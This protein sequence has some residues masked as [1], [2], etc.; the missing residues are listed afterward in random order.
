LD[1]AEE[2]LKEYRNK[3]ESVIEPS[4]SPRPLA[5]PPPLLKGG[6]RGDPDVEGLKNGRDD[7]APTLPYRTMNINDDD[8]LQD[9]AYAAAV[10]ALIKKYGFRIYGIQTAPAALIQSNDQVRDAVLDLAADPEL[11]VDNR[12]LLWMGSDVFLP[13]RAR[14]L[15]KL[16]PSPEGFIKLLGELE[17]RRIRH[18]HYWISSDGDSSWQELVEELALIIN[19]YRDFPNFGLLAHAPFIVPYPASRLFKRL[20]AETLNLKIKETLDAPDPAF[21]YVIADRLETNFPNLN[22]LLNNEEK[23]V[24]SISSRPRISR[25]PRSWRIIY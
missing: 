6:E 13:Q 15:G 21:R 4:K 20:P 22:R 19:Y 12:P 18:Y 17:K 5:G 2:L 14:R 16:L 25:L 7:R 8:I 24:F 9:P 10:F 11:Y 1:K 23:K 3:I